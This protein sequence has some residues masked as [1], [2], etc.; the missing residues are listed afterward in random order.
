MTSPDKIKAVLVTN[1]PAP[2]RVPMLRRVAE[3]NDIDLEVIYCAQ[4]HI[5]PT[6]DDDAHGFKPHFLQGRYLAME[7]RFMHADR[8][9]L[10]LL[11]RL[12]PDVVITTGYIPTFLFAFGW[13][14]LRGIA[15]VVMTDGTAQSESM[16][17]WAHRW[18]RRIVFKRSAAFVGASKGSL[19]LFRGYGLTDD[20]LHL[21]RLC[22]H[23][24]RFNL[25][26]TTDAA[27]FI[28][29]GRF[30]QHKRPIFAMQVARRVAEILGRKTTIH[31][32]G[33]GAM[34]PEMRAYA[35]T[36]E[37]LVEVRFLGYASQAELPKRYAAARVFLFPSEWD[38][39]GLVANEACAS[40]LPV[41][42][43]PHAGVAGELIQDGINGYVRPLD[44]E[45]WAEVAANLLSDETLY[46]RLSRSGRERVATYNFDNSAAALADAI[47][48]AAPTAT[49]RERRVCIVQ[50]VAKH[51]RLPFFDGLYRRLKE[52]GVSLQV[53]Y[54][55]PNAIEALRHD[56]V[57][58]P[59]EYGHKVRAFWFMNWH[60]LYQPVL[61]TALTSDL[62]IVEQSSKYVMNYLFTALSAVGLVRYAYWGHG[63][64]WQQTSPSLADRIKRRLLRRVDWWFA[65]TTRVAD[66]VRTNG[67]NSERITVVQ[68]S[69]ELA[70]FQSQ[71]RDVGEAGKKTLRDRFGIGSED[72]VGLFCGSMHADKNL[73][74]LVQAACEIRSRLPSF[75]LVLVGAGPVDAIARDAAAQHVWIHYV[76]PSFGPSRAGYFAIA[77]V[78]LCPGLVGLA[79]LDAFAA[80]LPLFTTDIPIHSPEIDY[81][82]DGLNGVMTVCEPERYAEAVAACLTNPQELARLRA[83]AESS[84]QRYG[85]NAMVE[86]FSRGILAC[87]NQS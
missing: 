31:F 39:W 20:K 55:D 59:P 66:Y 21:S 26:R 6:L 86:N 68:N 83:N 74:F 49:K 85:M 9:I 67:F 15:H 78:F 33:Q 79:V 32:L 12:R 17:S 84:S 64:N 24:D 71:I 19:E 23:N 14:A 70:E 11:D 34:E 5:D 73:D 48:Q 27:D 8:S 61:R 81:L 46:S 50:A 41:V 51:Y 54:S 43:S 77:D 36:I 1:V 4:P 75:H 25:Q 62:V 69:V 60:V 53:V 28:F 42:V 63:R 3:Q 82:D 29:C 87:L 56:T 7:K 2:Y 57:D 30:L 65:Y 72:Q 35:A 10:S 45:A 58:L 47:R 44:L 13:T 80:G 38:C 16:L 76:G 18:V 40:G 37:D 22:V 52:Q